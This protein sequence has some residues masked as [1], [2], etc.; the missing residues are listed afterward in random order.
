MLQINVSVDTISISSPDETSL[1]YNFHVVI[2][3]KYVDPRL[4]FKPYLTGCYHSGLNV[5]PYLNSLWTPLVLPIECDLSLSQP[6]QLDRITIFPNGEVHYRKRMKLPLVCR[7][8]MELFPFD[9]PVCTFTLYAHGY[10]KDQVQLHWD[11][12][13]PAYRLS[14]GISN[15]N[16]HPMLTD[17]VSC[18]LEELS[19][20]NVACIKAKTVFTRERTV[21]WVTHWIPTFVL[22]TSAFMTFWFKHAPPRCMIGTT[23]RLKYI[24]TTNSLRNQLPSS[25]DLVA[26]NVWDAVSQILIYFCLVEYIFVDY[27]NRHPR[28]HEDDDKEFLDEA[29]QREELTF[30]DRWALYLRRPNARIAN[31]VDI[32]CRTTMPIIYFKFVIA[33]FIAH[34]SIMSKDVRHSLREFENLMD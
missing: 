17:V 26:M 16:V 15:F 7:S 12:L 34:E 29:F 6:V 22:V 33:Y 31:D 4:R 18:S 24:T 19:I 27:L 10:R 1:S 8:T 30:C 32:V 5:Y 28:E 2:T 25:S 3:H 20:Y 23:T 11:M 14:N 13:A 9:N 21:Y